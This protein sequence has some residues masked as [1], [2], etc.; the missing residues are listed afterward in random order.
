MKTCIAVTHN[1]RILRLL[2]H[3]M[4]HNVFF[5]LP[6]T[7]ETCF[8]CTRLLTQTASF[9]L[10]PKKQPVIYVFLSFSKTNI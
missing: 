5:P 6:I 4:Y 8:Y 9:G 2:H 10:T 3:I 1:F 7:G